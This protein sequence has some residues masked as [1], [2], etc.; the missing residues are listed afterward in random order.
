M[1]QALRPLREE[2]VAEAL[3]RARSDLAAMEAKAG[4][5]VEEVR[6]AA[7]GAVGEAEQAG[8]RARR[9]LEAATERSDARLS[10]VEDS[11]AALQGQVEEAVRGCQAGT[12]RAA[13]A[14]GRAREAENRAREQEAQARALCQRVEE[15]AARL[16]ARAGRWEEEAARR[17]AQREASL[18]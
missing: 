4:E 16:R 13:E 17:T 6:R 18:A 2:A 14:Q 5:R 15:E 7:A 11:L 12:A 10:G 8:A 3:R 1:Q 9:V